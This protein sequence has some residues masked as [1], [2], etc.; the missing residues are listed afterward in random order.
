MKV[1]GDEYRQ[2]CEQYAKQSGKHEPPCIKKGQGFTQ[3]KYI[4]NPLLSELDDSNDYRVTETELIDATSQYLVRVDQMSGV[5]KSAIAPIA[6]QSVR[7]DQWIL[8]LAMV[9]ALCKIR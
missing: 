6:I 2:R 8:Y 9:K 4:V 5:S 3:T 7:M 1:A